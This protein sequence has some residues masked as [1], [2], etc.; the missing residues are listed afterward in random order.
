MLRYQNQIAYKRNKKLITRGNTQFEI[1]KELHISQ[2][3]ISRDLHYIQKEID[4]NKKDYGE[5]LFEV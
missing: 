3:T 4:K 2:P 5:R 1:S